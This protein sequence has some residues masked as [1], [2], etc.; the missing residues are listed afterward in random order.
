MLRVWF[1]IHG[2]GR[3]S[4]TRSS[5][6]QGRRRRPKA[7]WDSRLHVWCRSRPLSHFLQVLRP[8]S[9]SRQRREGARCIVVKARLRQ[10]GDVEVGSF[11]ADFNTTIRPQR[12]RIRCFFWCCFDVGSRQHLC[13]LHRPKGPSGSFPNL[14]LFLIY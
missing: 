8:N 9:S 5:G 7:S 10:Q 13:R 4:G 3:F 2:G 14:C 6:R 1:V 11:S 12:F